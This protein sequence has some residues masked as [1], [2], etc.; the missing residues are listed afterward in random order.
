M[1]SSIITLD[2]WDVTFIWTSFTNQ[3]NNSGKQL[4][5]G[6]MFEQNLGLLA[7]CSCIGSSHITINHI[8]IAFLMNDATKIYFHIPMSVTLR[9]DLLLC[10]TCTLHSMP[11]LYFILL[12]GEACAQA[13]HR[14]TKFGHT[15]DPS[16][17]SKKAFQHAVH[18]L[19]TM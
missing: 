16:Q 5:L 13:H 4:S 10:N 2:Y 1:W 17:L 18:A 14:T 3:L 6:Q 19:C 11:H 8:D 12:F 9:S 15:Y 7:G